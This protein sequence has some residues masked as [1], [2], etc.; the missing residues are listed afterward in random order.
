MNSEAQAFFDTLPKW[1]RENILQSGVTFSTRNEL[2]EIARNFSNDFD[3][4]NNE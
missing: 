1:L 2:E 3:K 4:S